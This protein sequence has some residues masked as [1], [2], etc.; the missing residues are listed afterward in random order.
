MSVGL[1]FLAAFSQGW[2]H[3]G[4][5]RGWSPTILL[6]PHRH[7]YFR[8]FLCTVGTF[9]T[10]YPCA[11]VPMYPMFSFKLGY[12]HVCYA[13]REFDRI[14]NQSERGGSLKLSRFVQCRHFGSI[15][16]LPQHFFPGANR[17]V[18]YKKTSEFHLNYNRL[19]AL[20]LGPSFLKLPYSD[21]NPLLL[22]DPFG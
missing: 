8:R 7:L 13:F 15:C 1:T 5:L 12:L 11:H 18:I 16:P 22:L 19:R 10:Y 3:R 6:S 17:W 20:H 2:R 21:F 9:I 4:C 14:Y